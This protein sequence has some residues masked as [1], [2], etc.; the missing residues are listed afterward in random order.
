MIIVD[1]E[2]LGWKNCG[3]FYFDKELANAL[4]TE[5]PEHRQQLGF[6]IRKDERGILGNVPYLYKKRWHKFFFRQPNIDLWH[7][8]FQIKANIPSGMPVVQTIHDLNY[9]HEETPQHK[10]KIIHNNIK[11]YIKRASHIVAISDYVKNDILKNFDIEG[12]PISVIYNGCNLYTEA[13]K[14]PNYKPQRPF[15]FFIG[16]MLWKKN[17]QVL[18]CLLKG[19]N[20]ELVI[21]GAHNKSESAACV[22]AIMEEAK[23]W[24]VQSRVHIT[25][26]IND[27]EKY[28]YLQNCSA[29]LFP[30]LAEGF[31][32]PVIEAMQFGKPVFLSDYTCLPEI[33]SKYAYYFNHDFDRNTMIKEFNKGMDDYYSKPQ[34]ADLIKKHAMQFSWKNAAKSYWNIYESLLN[35]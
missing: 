18:P 1:C 3:I 8:T 12:K 34:L 29:F 30:S 9:L 23:S 13:F 10:K 32:L 25:G 24:G 17:S 16:C 33:G 14:I 6:Y 28:W 4:L 11:R 31:G 26:A 15:L 21:A 35:N 27:A 7:S 5:M 19:N 2:K 20:Y 22:A